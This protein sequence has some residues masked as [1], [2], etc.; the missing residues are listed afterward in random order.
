MA[1]SYIWRGMIS[2][3]F[4]ATSRPRYCDCERWTMMDSAST[5]SPLISM[6]TF[7]TSE[8]LHVDLVATLLRTER[9]DRTHV[10]LRH[11]QVHGHDRLADLG[12]L[13]GLRHLRRVLDLDRAAVRLHDFVHHGRR[14][15]DQVHVE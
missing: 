2:R 7:T 6:S 13:R 3:I 4:A 8:V 11:V 10:L 1:T 12:N 5:L 9:D 14:R 15:G